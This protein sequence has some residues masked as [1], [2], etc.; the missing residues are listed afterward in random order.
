M[1]YI[2][3]T[4]LSIHLIQ[5][6]LRRRTLKG[7]TK[8]RVISAMQGNVGLEMARVHAPDLILLD[9]HLP[10]MSGLQVL[11][12]LKA[13]PRTAA[14]PVVVLTAD[15]LPGTVAQVLDAGA[16]ACLSKPIDVPAFLE[17]ITPIL[18]E[19]TK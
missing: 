18:E 8:V 5:G 19:S 12:E 15:A 1:L 13:D 6:I 17:T 3:D 10:D 9:L 14:M 16:V 4:L 2:E 11:N 7:E